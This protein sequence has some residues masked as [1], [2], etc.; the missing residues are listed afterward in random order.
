MATE[1]AIGSQVPSSQDIVR[2]ERLAAEG[3]GEVDPFD[4]H[5]DVDP[6][7][8]LPDLNPPQPAVAAEVTVC[9][10]LSGSV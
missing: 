3:V 1:S 9:A 2:G 4:L 8:Q 6:F 5:P 7:E 10:V